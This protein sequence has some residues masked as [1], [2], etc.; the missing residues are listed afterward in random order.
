[1]A[2]HRGVDQETQPDIHAKDEEPAQ[3]V[4]DPGAT[5]GKA[6]PIGS[7]RRPGAGEHEAE[8]AETKKIVGSTRRPSLSAR[9]RSCRRQPLFFRL[10]SLEA[11][12]AGPVLFGN[13]AAAGPERGRWHRA[14][15]LHRNRLNSRV[16]SY[17]VSILSSRPRVS[18]QVRSWCRQH[19]LDD[20]EERHDGV[21]GRGHLDM[22]GQDVAR[23]RR[24]GRTICRSAR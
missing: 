13:A 1:M 8:T 19:R 24:G 14:C 23:D 22:A 12:P 18:A 10:R 11:Q 21:P 2:R 6:A 17:S 15:Q 3:V 9:S 16:F 7:A 4:D 20:G 5:R